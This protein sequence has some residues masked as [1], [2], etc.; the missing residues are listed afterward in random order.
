M[1]VEFSFPCRVP[2]SLLR[3]THSSKRC[4]ISWKKP[5]CLVRL[6]AR[7]LPC[8]RLDSMNRVIPPYL[9]HIP[10]VC[11]TAYFH[12]QKHMVQSDVYDSTFLYAYPLTS[13]YDVV[14]ELMWFG[15]HDNSMEHQK[16]SLAAKYIAACQVPVLILIPFSAFNDREVF[17]VKQ[18]ICCSYMYHTMCFKHFY[19]ILICLFAQINL[20]KVA[21]SGCP[22][23]LLHRLILSVPMCSPVRSWAWRTR[24]HCSQCETSQNF[25]HREAVRQARNIWTESKLLPLAKSYC[26]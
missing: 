4:C 23:R 10:Y 24:E 18:E 19:K 3:Y 9:G 2:A 22:R 6:K 25:S 8:R 20:L 12:T 14:Y 7:D 1:L 13:S 11:R 26:K 17:Q 5:I 21:W 15:T 16:A